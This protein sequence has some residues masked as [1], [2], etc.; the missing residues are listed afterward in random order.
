MDAIRLN[1]DLVDRDNLAFQ[2]F[3]KLV[4]LG[5]GEVLGALFEAVDRGL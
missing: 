5:D 2:G 4:Y 3:G 1:F